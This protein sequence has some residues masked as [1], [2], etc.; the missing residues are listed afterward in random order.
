[1][2]RVRP[3]LSQEGQEW[4]DR[5]GRCLREKAE[6]F[7]LEASCEDADT[8][9]ISSH[10]SCY[11]QTG[12]CQISFLEKMKVLRLIYRELSDSR[13]LKEVLEISKGCGVSLL[14]PNPNHHLTQPS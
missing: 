2:G 6:G 5:V 7:S 14:H 1:M 9:A 10:S 11:L 8:A 13:I 4:M 12:F 3:Q